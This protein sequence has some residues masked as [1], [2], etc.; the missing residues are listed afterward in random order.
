MTEA[1]AAQLE[2]KV[3]LLSRTLRSHSS[4]V[5]TAPDLVGPSHRDSGFDAPFRRG[6][7]CHAVGDLGLVAGQFVTTAQ[8]LFGGGRSGAT[9]RRRRPVAR[10][11]GGG[12]PETDRIAVVGL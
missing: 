8:G 6:L 4:L 9:V 3:P 1:S 11:S 7:A 12:E 5:A 2:P 10:R